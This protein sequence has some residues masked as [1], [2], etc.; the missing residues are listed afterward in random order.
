MT[1]ENV[2]PNDGPKIAGKKIAKDSGL[3]KRKN[4]DDGRPLPILP[5]YKYSKPFLHEAVILGGVPN[6]I[7]YASKFDRILPFENIKE[8][9]RVLRPYNREARTCRISQKC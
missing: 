1:R 8:S 9:S 7:S 6:F 3:K 2:Y 4:Q 5:T